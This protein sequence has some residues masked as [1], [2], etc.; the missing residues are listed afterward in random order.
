MRED[1]FIYAIGIEGYPSVKIGKT[2]GPVTK[3]LAA[4]QIA[5]PVPLKILAVVPLD[6][7]VSRIEKAIH[8]FLE[9]ERQQGE[10]FA[11]PLTSSPA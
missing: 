6:H 5:Q 2:T 7:N 3:R 4:L 1:G 8:R 10:W 9:A 11:V